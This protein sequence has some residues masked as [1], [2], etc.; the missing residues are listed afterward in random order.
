MMVEHGGA[1]SGGMEPPDE[2]DEG[3]S[4]TRRRALLAGVGG[5]LALAITAC[6][7]SESWADKAARSSAGAFTG[8]AR[9]LVWVAAVDQWNLG[10]D[11]GFNE[12]CKLLGWQYEKVGY[13]LAKYS[14][15]THVDAIKRATIAR[16]DVLVAPNWV[17]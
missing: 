2:L 1:S 12:A 13:P 7:G 17:A 15:A 10:V 11:V 8:K 5:G 14:A 3:S 6:G 4:I 16:P 9:K